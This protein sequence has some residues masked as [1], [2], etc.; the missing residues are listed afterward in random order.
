MGFVPTGKTNTLVRRLFYRD[1]MREQQLAAEAAMAVIRGV[2]ARISAYK[3]EFHNQK[4]WA[5]KD[6]LYEKKLMQLSQKDYEVS[7]EKTE[8]PAPLATS[9][10][11]HLCLFQHLLILVYYFLFVL[12]DISIATSEFDSYAKLSFLQAVA[13]RTCT[14]HI[15]KV[16]IRIV[17]SEINIC[18]IQCIRGWV[19]DDY[20][21]YNWIKRK[22]KF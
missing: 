3:V 12:D 20:R 19:L 7:V 9:S 6:D 4:L 14:L 10:V 17:T 8:P 13:L 18:W 21:K 11:F 16:T 15:R 1:G 5:S 2:K 22:F